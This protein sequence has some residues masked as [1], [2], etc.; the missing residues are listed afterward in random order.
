MTPTPPPPFR[1]LIA[2]EP[3]LRALLG[4]PSELVL[5]KQI[6]A[7]D[8]HCRTFIALAPFVAVAT[9]DAAGRADVSPRGD[10][11]GFVQVLDDYRLAIP[12]RPGNRRADTLRNVL[13]TGRVGLLFI[14]PG[15]EETLRVNG[16]AWLTRDAALLERMTA[17]GKMP[18]LAI[19]VAVEEAFLHCAK[20]FKR[21]RLWEADSWPSREALPSLA[22]M[23]LDQAGPCDVTLDELERQVADS[24][25]TR[26]Y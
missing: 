8:G 7:L 14:I 6:T 18:P 12:E 25:V 16:R 5:K 1:D 22:S 17:R 19:G 9:A 3:A 21:S 4:T 20:A 23:L 26:L 2:D 10:A 11:P 15:F 24:Y 13:Q